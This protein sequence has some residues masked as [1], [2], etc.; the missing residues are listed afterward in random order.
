[1][2]KP[3]VIRTVVLLAVCALSCIASLFDVASARVLDDRASIAIAS[4]RRVL[5]SIEDDFVIYR[6]TASNDETIKKASR[7]DWQ[8]CRKY[9]SDTSNCVAFDYNE[10]TGKCYLKGSWT[11][12]RAAK[13]HTSGV[14]RE[15]ANGITVI[16]FERM[17]DME[18]GGDEISD[19]VIRSV[20]SR[21]ACEALCQGRVGQG[22]RAYTWNSISKKCFLKEDACVGLGA[23]IGRFSGRIMASP[24]NAQESVSVNG[25]SLREPDFT[26][27]DD[28]ECG[29]DE[30]PEGVLRRV[31]SRE[32]CESACAARQG[33]CKAY[34]WNSISKRCYLKEDACVPESPDKGRFSGRIVEAEQDTTLEVEE[35]E[36]NLVVT[37]TDGSCPETNPPA[38][39]NFYEIDGEVCDGN[40]FDVI[41]LRDCYESPTRENCGGECAKDPDCISYSFDTFSKLCFFYSENSCLATS[42]N[43]LYVSGLNFID[44]SD[45]PT[46]A[47]IYDGSD[48][49]SDYGSA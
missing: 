7:E 44:E 6:G 43:N 49:G 32:S 28:T 20:Q 5:N 15:K 12:T 42:V 38:N 17:D 8:A 31:E 18:C 35:E 48:Y 37:E 34:T 29:G 11:K 9:C 47:P 24:P 22:C 41:D 40:E 26:R 16:I 39:R 45:A 21:E 10:N 2:A 3:G 27:M 46:M 23:D 33:V 25:D 30:I 36:D 19:G 4:G 13:S 1:M 14:L